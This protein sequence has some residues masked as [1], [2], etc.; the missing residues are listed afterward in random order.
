[1]EK[2]ELKERVRQELIRYWSPEQIDV[3]MIVFMSDTVIGIQNVKSCSSHFVRNPGAEDNAV[4][5]F[6]PVI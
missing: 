6:K 5:G 2:P 4:N 1:M 3:S